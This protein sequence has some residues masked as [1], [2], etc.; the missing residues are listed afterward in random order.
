M[1]HPIRLKT[2]TSPL[3]ITLALFC[4]GLL[5]ERKRSSRPRTAVI[6]EFTTA[7]GNSA[8]QNLTTGV[9]NT[10]AGWHSLFANTTGNLNTAIGAGTLLFNTG[11]NNTATGA[12]ALLSNTTG[13]YNTANGAFALFSN[14]EGSGTRAGDTRRSLQSDGCQQCR[15]RLHRAL[16][17]PTPPGALI[18]LSG[19]SRSFITLTG[20][21]NTATGYQALALNTTGDQ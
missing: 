21:R 10:A 18:R 2:T 6:P 3:L 14:T 9:G 12:L 13:V 11:D 20:N 7:E 16:H 1:N 15:L 17:S 8:L 4:F 5:P 19:F